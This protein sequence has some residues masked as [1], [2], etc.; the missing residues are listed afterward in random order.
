MADKASF[1]LKKDKFEYEVK[2]FVPVIR[3]GRRSK[4]VKAAIGITLIVIV[5]LLI[6]G[7]YRHF[8]Y[9]EKLTPEQACKRAIADCISHT[10]GENSYIVD[11]LDGAE[12]FDVF[13]NG[14]YDINA[15]I[16]L[17]SL[18]DFGLGI[19]EYV[20][21]AGIKTLTSVDARENKLK[22]KLDVTWTIITIP[23]IE[24]Q[25]DKDKIVITSPE[26]FQE[27]ILI[28]K[29]DID[30]T[31]RSIGGIY[32]LVT[33]SEM[34][35]SAY[36]GME[37]GEILDL[38]AFE[39]TYTELSETKE[40][41]V[42]GKEETCYGY[43]I[44]AV[45]ELFVEP[46][47]FLLYMDR[48][49][50]LISLNIN[51]AH[52]ID[53]IP[54]GFDF[55]FMFGGKIHPSDKIDGKIKLYAGEDEIAGSFV[56]DTKLEDN[57]IVTNFTG[58]LSIPRIEELGIPR[59]DYTADI[60]LK[61]NKEKDS[62]DVTAVMSDGYDV[63]DI[64]IKGDA[65]NDTEKGVLNVGIDKFSFTYSDREIFT[66]SL[67]LD[68]TLPEDEGEEIT[69]TAKEPVLDLSMMTKEDIIYLYEQALS[70]VGKYVEMLED[71]F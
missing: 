24:Y 16:K 35:P 57:D 20:S 23:L 5:S 46:V 2:E 50:R 11:E 66:A 61:F 17:K 69:V 68:F 41:I 4:A 53:D 49:Y 59:I 54:T 27:S 1:E 42:C 21:G 9:R 8:I 10:F 67:D 39:C 13:T 31:D 44:E 38:A 43:K 70:R 33:G 40:M 45:S 14:R 56:S 26:F 36:T 65:S 6:F 58:E 47:E 30:F 22:G 28:N 19:E 34:T 18:A 48:E 37:I 12:W 71:F 62:F 29:N 51:Y 52:E 15:K 3:K 64:L 60:D 25:A 63:V 7:L 55:S 32:E